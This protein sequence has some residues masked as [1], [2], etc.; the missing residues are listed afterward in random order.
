MYDCV[1]AIRIGR[2]K[3]KKNEGV[4]GKKSETCLE[5]FPYS[6]STPKKKSISKKKKKKWKRKIFIPLC[7][8]EAFWLGVFSYVSL[9]YDDFFLTYINSLWKTRKEIDE[10]HFGDSC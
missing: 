5:Y 10:Q 4:E 2:S 1:F 3:N 8:L 9:Y 6:F 7:L